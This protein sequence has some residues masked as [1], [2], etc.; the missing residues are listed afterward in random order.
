MSIF[1]EDFA[2]VVSNKNEYMKEKIFKGKPNPLHEFFKKF[3][4]PLWLP[5]ESTERFIT[6]PGSLEVTAIDSS[7]Y[8]NLLSTG[9]IFY[10][11]QSLAMQKGTI[12]SKKLATDVVFSKEGT[13]KIHE[14][15]TIKME[16]LEFEAAIDALKKGA[17]NDILL[18]DG[19]LYGRTAHMPL[20]T[21]VEE[22]RDA[23]LHYF[24]LYEELLELCA[25][26]DILLVGVSKE[27]RSTFYRDYLLSLI[28][29]E[30]L[31]K[32]DVEESVKAELS[33]VFSQVLDVEKVAF[34]KFFRLKEVYGEKLETIELI[35]KELASSRP[36]YQLVMNFATKV[37][38]THPLLLGPTTG[39]SKL[40][41]R[42]RNDPKQ[43]IREYFPHSTRER[44]EAFVNWASEII[45]GISNFPSFISFYI[46]LDP[47]DSPLRIDLPYRNTLLWEID[48]PKPINANLESLLKVIVT[49]YCGLSAYNI[50][51]KAVDEKV[52]LRRK[53]V[54]DL[55]FPCME[56][57]FKE[58]IIRGRGYRRVKYP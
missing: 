42:F 33:G 49:G 18:F 28:F 57:L 24:Q 26:E 13:H 55:Y 41:R 48:W 12:I 51:L 15:I 20:E 25:K 44:G 54:D 39:I 1:L 36:D 45:K 16:M 2:T 17:V 8:T 30:E 46:L 22:E 58:K 31:K 21:K 50:W 35:L 11:V 10:I 14:F 40:L 52:R 27:S 53:I 37:G 34:D 6:N 9:G 19:S 43:F 3:F 56:K 32:L 23:L 7:V 29:N 5:L 38:Y 47:R 4:I